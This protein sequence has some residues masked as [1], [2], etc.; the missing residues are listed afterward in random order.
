MSEVEEDA[1]R[2]KRPMEEDGVEGLDEVSDST[3]SS[4]SKT[5]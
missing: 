1:R 5:G 4:S 2:L 3:A